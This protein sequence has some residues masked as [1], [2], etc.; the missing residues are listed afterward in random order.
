MAQ[1]SSLHVQ[2]EYIDGMTA[3]RE[4]K[5]LNAISMSNVVS[6][7]SAG[8]AILSKPTKPK[9]SAVL[10]AK[11]PAPGQ[12]GPEEES[13]SI[14]ILR[15]RAEAAELELQVLKAKQQQGPPTGPP[16]HGPPTGPPH[17]RPPAWI[18]QQ[19]SSWGPQN[20]GGPNPWWNINGPWNGLNHNKTKRRRGTTARH[21]TATRHGTTTM[22]DPG[23]TTTSDPGTTTTLGPGTTTTDHGTTIVVSG[24]MGGTMTAIMATL[25][26]TTM[27]K[28]DVESKKFSAAFWQYLHYFF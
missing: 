19:P 23:T 27:V 17:H 2:A 18:N 4:R 6:R 13:V 9:A 12:E 25:A 3:E 8:R 10:L 21:G 26:E 15:F 1:Q 7:T 16:Q 24:T 20:Y 22:S 11:R 28:T 5:Q 14:R